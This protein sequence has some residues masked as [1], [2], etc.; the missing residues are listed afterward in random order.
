LALAVS[1]RVD[2]DR[3][4]KIQETTIVTTIVTTIEQSLKPVL[5]A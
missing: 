3:V 2:D 5:F 4:T 1:I